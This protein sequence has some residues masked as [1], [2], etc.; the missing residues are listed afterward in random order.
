[1]CLISRKILFFVTVQSKYLSP[2]LARCAPGPFLKSGAEAA[3]RVK[4]RAKSDILY[5]QLRG[6]QQEF[7]G[8]YP[9]INQVLVGRKADFPGEY[10]GEIIG[11]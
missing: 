1:M 10:P 5:R 2:I 3:L 4:P 6:F 7:R 8:G 9:D 11:T